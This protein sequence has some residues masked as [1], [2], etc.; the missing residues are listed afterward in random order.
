VVDGPVQAADGVAAEPLGAAGERAEPV[1]RVLVRHL[2]TAVTRTVRITR[3]RRRRRRRRLRRRGR[4]VH[5][6]GQVPEL[7]DARPGHRR[8]RRS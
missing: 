7:M 3:V 4:G 5:V 6:G 8:R 1:V 2:P